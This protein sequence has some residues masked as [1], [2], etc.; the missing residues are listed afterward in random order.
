MKALNHK[1]R[2]KDKSLIWRLLRHCSVLLHH[3]EFH[4]WVSLI[5]SEQISQVWDSFMKHLCIY[6]LVHYVV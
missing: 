1:Q 5:W 2:R 6:D 4:L 3:V